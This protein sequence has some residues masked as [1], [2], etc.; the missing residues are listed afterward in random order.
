MHTRRQNYRLSYSDI[1]WV[2]QEVRDNQ[3]VYFVSSQRFAQDSLADLVLV[4][5]VADFPNELTL[6]GV[7]VGV[8]M[9]EEHFVVVI[10]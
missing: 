9:G 8:A 5:H 6:V 2:T 10:C 3:H 4:V 1:N 7:S